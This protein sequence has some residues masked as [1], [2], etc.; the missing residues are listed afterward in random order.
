MFESMTSV[1]GLSGSANPMAI[2]GYRSPQ[3]GIK[4]LIEHPASIAFIDSR[5]SDPIRLLSGLDADIGIFL[6]PELDG[7]TQITEVLSGFKDLERIDIITHGGSGKLQVG[8]GLLNADVLKDASLL[9]SE[10]KRHLTEDAD[11]LIYGCDVA[12]G[13]TGQAF[14]ND[15]SELTG[16][17][18]AAS[19]NL[20][21]AASQGG[22]WVLEY[23]TGPIDQAHIVS[24]SG[25]DS[26][27]G[28]LQTLFTNQL[29]LQPNSTDGNGVDWE[30]GMRFFS[31]KAGTIDAIRYFKSPGEVGS[32]IGRIW[33]ADGSLLTSV[34]FTNETASGWQQQKLQTPIS[35]QADTSYVVSVN[36]NSHYTK[37]VGGLTSMLSNGGLT[38]SAN[39]GVYNESTG[40]FPTNTWNSTNYFRDVAFTPATATS[41]NFPGT[42]ELTGTPA[43]GQLLTATVADAN[44]LPTAINYQWQQSSN[45]TTWNAISGATS[46]SL[47]LQQQQVGQRVRVIASYVDLRG[48]EESLTSV[49]TAVTTLSTNGSSVGSVTLNDTLE[50]FLADASTKTERLLATSL[51]VSTGEEFTVTGEE[52]SNEPARFDY[53]RFESANNNQASVT[54]EAESITN[55]NG[56][57][58]ESIGVASGGTALSLLNGTS[59]ETGTATFAFSGGTGLYNVILGTFDETDGISTFWLDRNTADE[60][61]IN[62]NT[63]GVVSISGTTMQGQMLTA[64][65]A[66]AD[67]LPGTINYRW[68]QSN[69][70]TTWSDITGA[71]TRTLTLQ[72][73][74]VGLRIRTL[75]AYVDLQGGI[76]SIASSLTGTVAQGQILAP[77]VATDPSWAVGRDS[78]GR[79]IVN[80]GKLGNL[81]IESEYRGSY[82]KESDFSGPIPVDRVAYD[83]NVDGYNGQ[84]LGSYRNGGGAYANADLAHPAWKDA[85]LRNVLIKNWNIKNAYKTI[86]GPH[87]DVTQIY[88]SVGWGGFFVAQDSSFKNSDDG[89]VQWQFGYNSNSLPAYQGKA[90]SDFG[91]VVVQGVTLNQEA[92]FVA[93][94]T[95][96]VS[97]NGDS[98]VRQGNVI[99]SWDPG[100]GWFIN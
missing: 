83:W 76:E 45:G 25:L 61:S 86:V 90:Q 14:V 85:A 70:G 92:A 93:D 80:S 100:V 22:D 62:Q 42:A 6:N 30:L 81:T 48:A 16:A 71:N 24:G 31:D 77:P 58:L 17:D 53:I 46:R 41:T 99:G 43:Q 78:S 79:L 55:R 68:Q 49:G 59:N 11:I 28:V 89:I 96:R 3:S 91:G 60:A 26:Y 63:A 19:T 21:G 8:S 69:D 74:Q 72:Q 84:P 88:D 94:A 66:D 18:V 56:Y 9:V 33:S 38:A 82:P 23:K 40:V 4:G 39:A 5:V 54:V 75:A 73:E 15:I 87:V 13:E 27:D 35:V 52:G 67:G 44:G 98:T 50:G 32:H 10:W 2:Q 97:L 7:I 37:S 47:T 1:E 57:R 51:N 64:T 65:V 34:T 20:T 36:A 29:P 95:A 12:T